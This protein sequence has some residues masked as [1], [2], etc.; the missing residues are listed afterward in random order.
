VT[1]DDPAVAQARTATDALRELERSGAHLL[2]DPAVRR[3]WAVEL[4]EELAELASALAEAVEVASG[5]S[6]PDVVEPAAELAG[7]IRRRRD[8]LGT[9]EA[10]GRPTT[11][12][13]P[14]VGNDE[15]RGSR[16][17]KH[18]AHRHLRP[19]R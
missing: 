7:A 6:G 17:P 16:G 3:R 9:L 8:A 5:T 14:A 4:L 10:L 1:F 2:A 12:V 13:L 18:R 11:P 15:G 19:V